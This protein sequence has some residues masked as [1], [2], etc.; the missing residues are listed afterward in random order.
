M[1]EQQAHRLLCTVATES[2]PPNVA[3]AAG[4]LEPLGIAVV[5]DEG[6]I[7]N[8]DQVNREPR[9]HLAFRGAGVR[10]GRQPP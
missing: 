8:A 5:Q 1:A 3:V 9:G 6:A 2:W 7:H 10:P 4:R